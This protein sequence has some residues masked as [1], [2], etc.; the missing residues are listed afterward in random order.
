MLIVQIFQQ[1][2]RIS[3]LSRQEWGRVADRK[4]EK[5]EETKKVKGE[6]S[7]EMM[8]LSMKQ[9]DAAEEGQEEGKHIKCKVGELDEEK[10]KE[11]SCICLPHC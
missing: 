4:W 10:G 8:K 2:N 9:E 5:D 1:H 11:G 7:Y 3:T 6:R